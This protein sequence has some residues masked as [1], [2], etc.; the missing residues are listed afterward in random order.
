M[1]YK[2]K[3]TSGM[4]EE[5]L[6]TQ[7]SSAMKAG[8]FIR[9]TFGEALLSCVRETGWPLRHVASEIGLHFPLAQELAESAEGVE[10]GS[11]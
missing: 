11:V 5:R 6:R 9:L 3:R 4:L 1:G 10:S 7:P 2:E 8:E